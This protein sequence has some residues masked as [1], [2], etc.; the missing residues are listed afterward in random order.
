MTYAIIST[1]ECFK[2]ALVIEAEIDGITCQIE[3]QPGN[4]LDKQITHVPT[5]R[6]VALHPNSVLARQAMGRAQ[7]LEQHLRPLWQKAIE[8]EMAVRNAMLEAVWAEAKS[9][10]PC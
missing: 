8:H 9:G 2:L 5:S 4:K 3:P 7:K 6:V 1:N 10:I